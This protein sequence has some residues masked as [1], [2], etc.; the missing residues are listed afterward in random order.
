V[1]TTVV[2]SWP[3]D[4]RYAAELARYHRGQL[5]NGSAEKLLTDVASA[6]IAQQRV[7]GV[8]EI[9]GGETSAD[10]FILHF[11]H[12]LSG[13]APSENTAAWDGRGTFRIT[14]AIGA[15][16]GLGIA[17]AFA[18]ERSI[19]PDLQKV[20]I[21][22]PSEITTMLEPREAARAAWPTVIEL[23]RAEMRALIEMGARDIQLDVPQIAMG[24][25][26]GGWDTALAVETIMA[27]F[28]GVRGV[29]RS[30]HLCYGDFGARTWARNR[31]LRPLLP[32]LR[33]LTGN[34]DR[35]V[36][37]LSLAEQW[38]DRHL[39]CDLD[40]RLEIAAG[41]VDVKNPRIQTVDE[42]AFMTEDL[43][44]VLA[45]RQILLC[46]SCGFGRRWV[47][48]AVDK[49]KVMVECARRF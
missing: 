13:I 38:A 30:L 12:L 23:I 11:P 41:L 8:D 48:L 1:R 14:G 6:A 10:S 43:L 24:L 46:P 16:D 39:L 4:A 36:I 34:I 32:T 2:G 28:D 15:P 45:P 29:R 22:G 42:L 40:E 49:T 17:R 47:R 5:D 20:T 37:E 7:C 33:H 3:P 26:D 19:D 44:G 21:P 27:I 9:T 25:A 31:S 35:V 18:R